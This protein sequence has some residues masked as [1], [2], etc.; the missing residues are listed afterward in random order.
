VRLLALLG[1][2]LEN[3]TGRVDLDADDVRSPPDVRLVRGLSVLRLFDDVYDWIP[4]SFAEERFA[5]QLSEPRSSKVHGSRSVSR[6]SHALDEGV[7]QL[8]YAY[9][10]Q[11]QL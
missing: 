10:T 8:L 3:V 2:S 11:S 5:R 9:A 6:P 1:F 4:G 7:S